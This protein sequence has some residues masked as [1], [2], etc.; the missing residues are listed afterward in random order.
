MLAEFDLLSNFSACVT[1]VEGCIREK[2]KVIPNVENE[3]KSYLDS[4]VRKR[5]VKALLKN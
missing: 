2:V 1:I 5:F 3:I 4:Y